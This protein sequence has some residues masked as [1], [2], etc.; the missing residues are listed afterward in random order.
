LVFEMHVLE[1][2]TRKIRDRIVM[3]EK[4]IITETEKE[5]INLSNCDE[6]TK[7]GEINGYIRKNYITIYYLLFYQNLVKVRPKIVI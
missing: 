2:L 4:K 6:E 1:S 5:V 3:A 7:N